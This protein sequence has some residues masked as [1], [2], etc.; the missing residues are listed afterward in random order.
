MPPN[1]RADPQRADKRLKN[2]RGTLDPRQRLPQRDITA[3]VLRTSSSTFLVERGGSYAMFSHVVRGMDVVDK[4]ARS[5]DR[6]SRR[7]P[8]RPAQAVG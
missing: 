2:R 4:I 1:R 8:G 7:A 5:E 6:Q 3:A